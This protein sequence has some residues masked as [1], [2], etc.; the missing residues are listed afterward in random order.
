MQRLDDVLEDRD[1]D[2]VQAYCDFLHHRFVLARAQA[3][4]VANDEAFQS[5]LDHGRPGYKLTDELILGGE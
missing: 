1:A 4:D 5:W 3:R 2:L